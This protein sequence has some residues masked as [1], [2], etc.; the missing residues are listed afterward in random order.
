LY[1]SRQ[2][3]RSSCV[4]NRLLK[5]SISSSSRR[6]WPLGGFNKWILPG[7]AGLDVAGLRVVEATPVAERLADELGAVVAA[8]QRGSAT[9]PLND[10]L[11]RAD[12]VVG[13]HPPCSRRRECFACVL[14]GD[15]EDLERPAVSGAVAD[16]IDRP[17]LIGTSC[18]E[19]AA[20]PRPAP[21]FLRLRRQPKPFVAPQPLHPLAIARPALAAQDR[22]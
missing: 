1:W 15:G 2:S 19:V 5:L 18:D 7:G 9:A 4:S 16:K 22:R 12:G 13:T 11:E 17:Y 6:R 21:T 20:H 14:V 10:Q 3:S 8:N